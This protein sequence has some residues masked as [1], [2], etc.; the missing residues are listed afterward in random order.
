MTTTSYILAYEEA[1]K[2]AEESAGNSFW[3]TP[4]AEEIEITDDMMA[5][6]AADTDTCIYVLARNAG[7]GA[8]RTNTPGDYELTDI[9]RANL[10]KIADAFDKVI[11][12][13]NAGGAID[14]KFIGEIEGIDLCL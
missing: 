5:E 9:E 14:T 6:A 3:S 4:R 10:E 12:V 11:L 7:E 8:D 2:L 1:Q 13:I